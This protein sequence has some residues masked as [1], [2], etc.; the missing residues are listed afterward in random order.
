[1]IK[2]INKFIF[3][4]YKTKQSD[5][6]CSDCVEQYPNLFKRIAKENLKN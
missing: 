3:F 5:R 1:M 2:I 4:C 6:K